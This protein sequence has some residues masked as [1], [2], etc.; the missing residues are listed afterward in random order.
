MSIRIICNKDV[1]TKNEIDMEK[2]TRE[3][4]YAGKRLTRKYPLRRC[5]IT[6][7]SKTV[8]PQTTSRTNQEEDMLIDEPMGNV[9]INTKSTIPTNEGMEAT[10]TEL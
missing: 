2:A 8:N 1:A 4:I 3:S 10:S 6:P 9:K 7:Y 5:S